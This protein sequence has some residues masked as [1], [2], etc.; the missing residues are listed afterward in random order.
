M[1]LAGCG[2]GDPRVLVIKFTFSCPR[3]P[4]CFVKIYFPVL[5]H[6]Q[7]IVMIFVIH[8]KCRIFNNKERKECRWQTASLH[9]LYPNGLDV[10]FSSFLVKSPIQISDMLLF[11][12]EY[13]E[14][15]RNMVCRRPVSCTA[16]MVNQR[17]L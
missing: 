12:Q 7:Y 2:T 4:C 9:D 15:V 10:S 3:Q 14:L 16:Y 13:T 5:Y 1:E 11:T 8:L 17:I 6:D